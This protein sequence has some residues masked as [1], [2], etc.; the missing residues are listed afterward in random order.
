MDTYCRHSNRKCKSYVFNLSSSFH[1]A[2][3]IPYSR[4]CFEIYFN[5]ML[6]IIFNKVCITTLFSPIVWKKASECANESRKYAM[7]FFGNDEKFILIFVFQNASM[8]MVLKKNKLLIIL[9]KV[10]WALPACHYYS[11]MKYIALS[12]V[13]NSDYNSICTTK[14]INILN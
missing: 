14:R 8:K 10:L 11:S 2:H 5:K 7:H 6:R 13:S 12:L 1:A 4:R 9:K 3:S